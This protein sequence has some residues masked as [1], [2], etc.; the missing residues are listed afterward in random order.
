MNSTKAKSHQPLATT[1][2]DNLA[3]FRSGVRA[4]QSYTPA[5]PPVKELPRPV[6]QRKQVC[7]EVFQ[8]VRPIRTLVLHL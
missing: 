5:D 6:V 2:A 7:W 1:G 3:D 8:I 4:I